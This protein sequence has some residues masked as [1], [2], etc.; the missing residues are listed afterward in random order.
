MSEAHDPSA[1]D[2]IRWTFAPNPENREAIEAHLVDLGLD[3]VVVGES[4][5]HVTWEEP[6]RDMA[7]V[8]SELW[9]LNGE[10][11]EITQEEFHR[12]GHFLIHA[13]DAEGDEVQAA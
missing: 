3:V 12:L 6:D 4:Q 7:E 8:T 1:V 5:F 11:F 2:M 10:P 9:D 13:D